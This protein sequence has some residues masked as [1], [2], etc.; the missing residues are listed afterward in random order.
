MLAAMTTALAVLALAATAVWSAVLVGV[1]LRPTGYDPL[2]NAVSDYGVGAHREWYRAQTAA[3]AVAALFLLGAFAAGTDAPW[4][5]LLL[6]AAFAAARLAIPWFP[7][8]LD[9]TRPTPTGRVHVLLAGVAF[10][11]IAIAAGNTPDQ[12]APRT[13]QWAV[14]VTAIAVAWTL[15]L[16]YPLFGLVERLFYAATVTWFFWTAGALL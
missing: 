6:L 16:R 10:A 7:T 1:H 8:D 3:S 11:S 13:L 15:R 14:V 4:W 2:R 5:E 9:R 12:L